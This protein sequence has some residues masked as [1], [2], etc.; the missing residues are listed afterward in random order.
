MEADLALGI[1]GEVTLLKTIQNN[2]GADLK[3]TGQY[4]RFDYSND[5]TL[6]ELKTRRCLSTTYPDTMI[7]FSKVKFLREKAKDK[8]AFF[9]FNFQDGVFYHEFLRDK[10]YKVK[11]G[12]R[13]DRGR[14]EYNQY[15]FISK[16]D[17]LPISI[18][19]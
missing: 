7:P 4:D 6:V 9:V 12:G 17:L 14:P 13:C 5:T 15:C 16:K 2:F 1:S 11:Q 18:D 3:P 10:T 19:F 8:K